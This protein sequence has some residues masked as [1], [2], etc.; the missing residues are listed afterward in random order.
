MG[1]KEK[2][3]VTFFLILGDV[4]DS[5]GKF[6]QYFNKTIIL[7]NLTKLQIMLLVTTL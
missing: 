1:S 7:I 5:E 3:H 2:K 6:G 4:N